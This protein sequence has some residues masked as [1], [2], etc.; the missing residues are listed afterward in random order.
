MKIDNI[1][2]QN[3]DE[4]SARPALF[5]LGMH[6]SAPVQSRGRCDTLVCGWVK[7]RN[8]RTRMSKIPWGSGK[9]GTY[10]ICAIKCCIRREPTGGRSPASN[11]KPSRARLWPS[12]AG[13][14]KRLFPSWTNIKPGSSRTAPLPALADPATLRKKP[15]L[16]SYPSQPSRSCAFPADAQ[17]LQHLRGARPLGGIQSSRLEGIRGSATHFSYIRITHAASG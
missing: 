12:N 7:K 13:T 6:R 8:S 3:L 1:V 16:H 2:S 9:D 14:L 17:R 4:T 5:V 11:R 10:A 15:C